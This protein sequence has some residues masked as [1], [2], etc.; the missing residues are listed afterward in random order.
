METQNPLEHTLRFS[1]LI[2]FDAPS[3]R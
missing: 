3:V 1:L 2:N